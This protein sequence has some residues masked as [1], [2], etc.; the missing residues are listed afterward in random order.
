MSDLNNASYF[1]ALNERKQA[2]RFWVD[3]WIKN[4]LSIENVFL[5]QQA[6]SDLYLGPISQGSESGDGHSQYP[7]F[8]KACSEIKDLLQN[9][10]KI[11]YLEIDSGNYLFSKPEKRI[12]EDFGDW[13]EITRVE[14]L[15]EVVGK[16]L[17]DYIK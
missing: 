6:N 9:L 11:L 15:S 3:V 14:L 1:D 16:E 10:P 5:I 4:N 7:G 17:V 2:L 12:M 8:Q 13:C